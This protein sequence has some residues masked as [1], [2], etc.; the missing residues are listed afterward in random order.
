MQSQVQPQLYVLIQ[1]YVCLQTTHAQSCTS[2]RFK[3]F[4]SLCTEGQGERPGGQGKDIGRGGGVG[5]GHKMLKV[6]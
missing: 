6:A 2:S 3:S 1:S 4:A 5:G